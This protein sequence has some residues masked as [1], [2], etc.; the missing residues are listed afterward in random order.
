MDN[1]QDFVL[2]YFAQIGLHVANEQNAFWEQIRSKHGQATI[3]KLIG[4]MQ[5]RTLHTE[6]PSVYE[7]IYEAKNEN[8]QLS[9]DF[10]SSSADFTMKFLQWMERY[11][12]SMKPE[13]ILEVGSDN[14]IVSCFLALLFPEAQVTGVEKSC[15]GILCAKTLA[16]Q[17]NLHNINFVQ[18]DF[19]SI[20]K[21]LYFSNFDLIVS[22][23]TMHEIMG[24]HKIRDEFSTKAFI[25]HLEINSDPAI[26]KIKSLLRDDSSIFISCERI[27]NS[28][29]LAYYSEILK[30]DGLYIQWNNCQY[31][32]FHE[33]LQNHEFPILIITGNAQ[34]MTTFEGLVRLAKMNS[35]DEPNAAVLKGVLAEHRINQTKNKDFH[36]G[37][38]ID[39][40]ETGE[41]LR[42]ECWS[43]SQNAFLYQYNNHFYHELQSFSVESIEDI[44]FEIEISLA[45]WTH[46]EKTNVFDYETLEERENL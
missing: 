18:A 14:G 17:L 45:K 25:E 42:L 16:N 8:L 44:L 23:K 9:I 11:A 2:K 41:K 6:H 7:N 22:L 13:R 3:D 27:S 30:Y 34:K 32:H 35:S 12:D 28:N 26:L 20:E 33:F 38:Q 5:D 1:H 21:D 39:W 10:S 4:I 46:P 31:N 19:L 24:Q 40:V 36:G 15:N 43:D 29:S 37:V